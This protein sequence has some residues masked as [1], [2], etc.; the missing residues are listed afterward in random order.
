[1]RAVRNPYG[2][3]SFYFQRVCTSSKH[4]LKIVQLGSLKIE[5]LSSHLKCE[6]QASEWHQRLY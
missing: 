3:D 2:P 4:F 6:E 5:D 1:M